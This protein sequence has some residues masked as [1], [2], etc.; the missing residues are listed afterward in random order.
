M[1]STKSARLAALAAG[2]FMGLCGCASP[3]RLVSYDAGGGVVAIPNNSDAWPTYNRRHAE[4]LMRAKFPGGYVIEKEEEVVVGQTQHTFTN[5]QRSGDAT[6]AALHIAP[7][8]ENTNQTTS[9]ED[10][11]EWRIYFRAAAG[12][13]QGPPAGR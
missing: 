10:Q 7:V 4:E 1:S 8:N 6:L 9:V 12:P 3:A 13:G 2:L 5:T 11:K